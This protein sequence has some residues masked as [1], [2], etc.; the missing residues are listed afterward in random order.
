MPCS[1]ETRKH[2]C[3]KQDEAKKIKYGISITTKSK[4][5]KLCTVIKYL[6]LVSPY[7]SMS[8]KGTPAKDKE[9]LMAG[10]LQKCLYI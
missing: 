9:K 8:T 10:Y 3:R 2:K 6:I 7:P 5:V 1:K 4:W